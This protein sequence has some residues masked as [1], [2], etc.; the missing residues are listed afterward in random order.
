MCLWA[1][2]LANWICCQDR[3]Y[4][5]YIRNE[6]D[7][8]HSHS[9][10]YWHMEESVRSKYRQ[11]VAFIDFSSCLVSVGRK[12]SEPVPWPQYRALVTEAPVAPQYY[13]EVKPGRCFDG[14][15]SNLQLDMTVMWLDLLT[16]CTGFTR[17]WL[18]D[19]LCV[20]THETENKKIITHICDI[21]TYCQNCSALIDKTWTKTSK[22]T[23]DNGF[24]VVLIFSLFLVGG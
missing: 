17:I 24:L 12:R 3:S 9:L 14:S 11:F 21:V 19:E 15:G 16:V 1:R 10:Y 8:R 13:S 22:S 6:K 4:C 7:I 23:G 20:C 5:S 2:T 18:L